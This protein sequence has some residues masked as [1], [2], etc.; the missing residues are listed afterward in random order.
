MMQRPIAPVADMAHFFESHVLPKEPDAVVI[1]FGL[2]GDLV[3]SYLPTTGVAFTL[4]EME[5]AI[6]EARSTGR[7]L[8]VYYGYSNFS[9]SNTEGRANEAFALLDNRALF[10]EVTS[11]AGVEAQFFYRILRFRGKKVDS[12]SSGD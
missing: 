1:G 6:A 11:F 7:P 8:W 12:P 5:K 2:G 4:E 9:R 3:Q 10:E